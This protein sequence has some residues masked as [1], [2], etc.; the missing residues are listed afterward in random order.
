M[1]TTK[2][3]LRYA[4]EARFILSDATYKLT[5]G[6]F[7]TLTGGTSDKNK[8]FHPFGTALCSLENIVDF[9]FFFRSIKSSCFRE[10]D[11]LI[12]PSIL[13]ADSAD[14]ITL[15]FKK[16]FYMKKRVN[17]WA[18]VIRNLEIN[19]QLV[20]FYYICGKKYYFC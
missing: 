10:F 4:L 3:L 6:G 15:G 17:C 8:N 5:Y 16:V 14:A 2:R 12:N 18:H 1:L 9:A 11:H 20:I 13:V 19:T 7:P